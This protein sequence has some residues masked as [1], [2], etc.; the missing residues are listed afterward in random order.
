MNDSFKNKQI[1]KI[2]KKKNKQIKSKQKKKESRSSII[3]S[4]FFYLFYL[5][6]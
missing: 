3:K 2:N 6:I 1:K 4:V 5:F